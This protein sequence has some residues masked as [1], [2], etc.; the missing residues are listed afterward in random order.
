MVK[1]IQVD[2]L[3]G[4]EYYK[5]KES[6]PATTVAPFLLAMLSFFAFYINACK[7]ESIVPF[8]AV[9]PEPYI[10]EASSQ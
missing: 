9:A 10:S 3:F 7:A 8:L 4:Q 6:H 1:V 2:P 5:I